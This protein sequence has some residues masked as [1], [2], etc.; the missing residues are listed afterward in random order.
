MSKNLRK[1]VLGG[2]SVFLVLLIA[3]LVGIS[4]ASDKTSERLITAR[5]ELTRGNKDKAY[6][7]YFSIISND[8]SCEE[9]YRVLAKLAEEK[10]NYKDSAYFW[11]MISNLNPLDV[12]AKRNYFR[13]MIIS[14]ADSILQLRFESLADKSFLPDSYIYAV[15]KSYARS[16]KRQNIADLQK[17]VKSS[18]Y[19]KMLVGVSYISSRNF[20]SA[21]AEFKSAL[22]ES[23][24]E[25]ERFDSMIGLASLNLFNG[26][27]QPAKDILSKINS[28][29][30]VIISDLIALQASIAEWEGNVKTA[31]LKYIE[32]AKFKRYL[33]APIVEGVELA[34]IA[35]DLDALAK[36][37]TLFEAKDK[38]SLELFYYI[39]AH[40]S[41]LKGD[42]KQSR[43]KLSA[44][45]YFA[46]GISGRILE[47][48]CI[49]KLGAYASASMIAS[50]IAKFA[51]QI[52]ES[53]KIEV[54]KI[55][56]EILNKNRNDDSLLDSLLIISPDNPFANLLNM[57]RKFNKRDFYSA[58]N[59]SK[60][61]LEK[62][63][64]SESTFNIACASAMA[65]GNYDDVIAI[66]N[67]KLKSNKADAMTIL[68]SARAYLAKKDKNNA[69]KFYMQAM[70]AS[71]KSVVIGAEV[72]NFMLDNKF[73]DDFL[74]TLNLIESSK[75]KDNKIL[76]LLLKSKYAKI[77]GKTSEQIELLENA[78]K[79]D[80]S[81]DVLLSE[82]ITAYAD[83]KK[84]RDVLDETEKFLQ[85]KDSAVLRF[86][87]ASLIRNGG[88]DFCTKSI[89][90]LQKLSQ[91]H[92]SQSNIFL[93]LSRSYKKA[94]MFDEALA[95]ARKAVNLAPTGLSAITN[96]GEILAFG[97]LYEE[98]IAT[99]E[100]SLQRQKSTEIESV[101][102]NV[103]V[104][105]SKQR[106]IKI[107]RRISVLK[108]ASKL[109]PDNK[110]I[111]A[112]ISRLEKML[113]K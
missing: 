95:S 39:S 15:A 74:A 7:I 13:A 97:N 26:D 59:S 17:Y 76:A 113:K 75:E 21:Q 100:R 2:L 108:K 109:H 70:K 84:Y 55:L 36:F 104:E 101:L 10:V 82:L 14:G 79:M 18:A 85:K 87:M 22:A 112:E 35:K 45:G 30:V 56:C 9:A 33:V 37:K 64:Y 107:D 94:G 83:A 54:V 3:L 24:N 6:S 66:A 71:Q 96:L 48:K 103:L 31:I 38:M 77:N 93:E 81:S 67:K 50:N 57:H 63:G 5:E 61:V 69:R 16:A 23:K 78:Y 58:Y 99:L 20:A 89:Q 53:D 110:E 11:L 98:A 34:S 68:F 72:G 106:D 43:E 105:F 40:E 62:L 73:Y 111:S 8:T 42:W 80:D 27:V 29:D 4:F 12:D 32:F 44:S 90:L 88:K 46:Q 102:V 60:I 49:S 91:E 47:L 19:K 28:D 1:F 41:F 65:L 25:T 92:S 51:N 86:R 52:T